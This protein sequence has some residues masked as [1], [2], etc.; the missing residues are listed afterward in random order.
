MGEEIM[1]LG[2]PDGSTGSPGFRKPM[3]LADNSA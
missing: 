2:L 3:K 1:H